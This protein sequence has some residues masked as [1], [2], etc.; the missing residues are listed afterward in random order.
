MHQTAQLTNEQIAARYGDAWNENDLE[1][2][3]A[4]QGEDMVFR[5]HID[6]FEAAIGPEAVRAQFGYFFDAWAGMHFETQEQHLSGGLFVHQFRFSGKL[7]KPFPLVSEVIEPSD[8]AVDVDGVDVISIR[9]ALVRSKHTYLDSLALR[10][11]L[12]GD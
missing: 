11:Q 12:D 6:G 5:L 1:T 8:Q 3:M 9:E 4:M 7:A 10:R 2:I